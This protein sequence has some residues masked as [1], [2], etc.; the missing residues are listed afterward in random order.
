MCVETKPP[1]PA[2]IGDAPSGGRLSPISLLRQGVRFCHGS[3][4]RRPDHCGY[5]IDEIAVLPFAGA[6]GTAA[7][8]GVRPSRGYG[9]GPR[10]IDFPIGRGGT[11]FPAS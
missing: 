2:G 10:W 11:W 6:R 8:W 5:A 3:A 9:E 7:R 4:R 1:S